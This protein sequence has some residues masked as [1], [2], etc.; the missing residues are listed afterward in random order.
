MENKQ[1][2]CE[3]S[4][5]LHQDHPKMTSNKKKFDEIYELVESE[6]VHTEELLKKLQQEISDGAVRNDALVKKQQLVATNLRE[7]K[8]QIT[9]CLPNSSQEVCQTMLEVNSGLLAEHQ[10]EQLVLRQYC[11]ELA[12]R[13]TKE[14]ESRNKMAELAIQFDR[15]DEDINSMQSIIEKVQVI[16]QNQ[17]FGGKVIKAQEEERR[18]VSREMHDGPA[19]AMANVVF[20]AEFCEKLI[21]VDANR[22]KSELQELRKQV[23]GCLDE[24]RKIVFNLRPMALDD[25]GLIPTVRKIV[26]MLRER[27]GI[28]SSITVTGKYDEPLDS[29]LEVGLFRIIQESLSNIEKH[30]HAT[31]VKIAI[32]VQDEAVTVSIEDNGDGFVVK[33]TEHHKDCFGLMGMRE[34]V[35][36]LK[37]QLTIDSQRGSGTKISV[38]I[39]LLLIQ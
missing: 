1:L 8:K 35:S 32:D 28:R 17:N 11:Q 21:D 27:T 18:R 10:R 38:R 9:T 25:L 39:P 15:M 24:T 2:L 30:S 37:G 26:E 14:R 36:L 6:A 7:L 23:L 12:L 31:V 5:F 13:L 33:D 22:A 19:Q 4:G 16:E 3:I 34:R 20:L 29:Q